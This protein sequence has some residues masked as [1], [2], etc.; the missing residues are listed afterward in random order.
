MEGDNPAYQE[1]EA[2]AIEHLRQYVREGQREAAYV[3]NLATGEVLLFAEGTADEINLVA[4]PVGDVVLLHCHLAISAPGP[5]DWESFLQ[6]IAIRKMIVLDPAYRYTVEKT[7]GWQVPAS[8]SVTG[9]S[10]AAYFMAHSHNLRRE[11]GIVSRRWTDSEDALE[12]ILHETNIQMAQR[13]AVSYS[14]EARP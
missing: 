13:F 10:V 14:G 3:L 4:H 6:E 2:R 1:A 7:E 12:V 5:E 9:I 8:L 11:I